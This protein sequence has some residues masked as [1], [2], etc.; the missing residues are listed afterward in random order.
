MGP[1]NI[2]T[3]RNHNSNVMESLPLSLHQV[4][5]LKE[6]I[7]KTKIIILYSCESSSQSCSDGR[8]TDGRLQFTLTVLTLY[9]AKD[10]IWINNYCFGSLR[11][12]RRAT[13]A[14]ALAC[15][16]GG[17]LACGFG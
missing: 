3:A 14:P 17:L 6:K 4:F 11:F 5:L 13:A 2:A 7:L 10:G 12:Q 8:R 9:C 1:G 16:F 15:G